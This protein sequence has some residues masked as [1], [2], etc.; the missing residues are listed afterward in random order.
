MAK[1]RNNLAFQRHDHAQC[2]DAALASARRVCSERGARLTPLRE[3]V[4]QLVW[5]SHKPLGAY[6]LLEQLSAQAAPGEGQR[7][8]PPTVYRALEFLREQGLVHR[9]DSLN[10][11]IGC[12]HPQEPHQRFF[13]ICRQ[14]ATAVEIMSE[15]LTTALKSV[16]DTA[17]FAAEGASVEITGLCS[18]CRSEAARP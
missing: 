3:S 16:A 13:L 6:T 4:L 10:A 11:F 14:C 18:A 15:P 17:Q 2:I 8:A 12:Q 1:S 9:I 5:Q 7:L